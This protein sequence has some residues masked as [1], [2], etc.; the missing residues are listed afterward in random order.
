MGKSDACSGA[1][2]RFHALTGTLRTLCVLLVS[3]VFSYRTNLAPFAPIRG[4]GLHPNTKRA[5]MLQ[6]SPLP[7]LS[8]PPEAKL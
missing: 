3:P 6:A 7:I 8:S 5:T 4:F 2:R 1:V